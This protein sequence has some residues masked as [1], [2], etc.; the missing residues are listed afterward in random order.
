MDVIRNELTERLC[1]SSLP[2]ANHQGV[3][4]SPK[5]VE[6]RASPLI[7]NHSTLSLANGDLSSSSLDLLS[8]CSPLVHGERSSLTSDAVSSDC[9]S[10]AVDGDRRHNSPI[11]FGDDSSSVTPSV[12]ELQTP[13]VD[14]LL[15]PSVDGV[16][17][18]EDDCYYC[19]NTMG[20]GDSSEKEKTNEG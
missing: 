12:D 16:P 6:I 19:S 7:L 3:D 4:E 5:E 10:W 2:Q 17:P 13:S 15:T 18:L 11:G 1:R 8:D 14:G 9:S 20:K